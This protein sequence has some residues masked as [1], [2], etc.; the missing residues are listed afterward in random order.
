MSQDLVLILQRVQSD[1]IF[2]ID[3][4]RIWANLSSFLN[5]RTSSTSVVAKRLSVW[6][7]HLMCDGR[8]G[9]EERSSSKSVVGEKDST[10]NNEG[11]NHR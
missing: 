4:F 10:S 7:A 8:E 11:R 2:F 3:C 9:S 6:E 5:V 1:F